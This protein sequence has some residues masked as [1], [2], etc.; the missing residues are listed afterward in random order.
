MRLFRRPS[1]GPAYGKLNDNQ[2]RPTQAENYVDARIT[3]TDVT[4]PR[5][6][7]ASEDRL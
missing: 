6:R 3:T 2:L 1:L 7:R 5:V 4:S